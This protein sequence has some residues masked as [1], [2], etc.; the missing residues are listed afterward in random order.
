[1]Q[2]LSRLTLQT[3]LIAALGK[4]LVMYEA[5]AIP[6]WQGQGMHATGENVLASLAL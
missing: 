1:M 6:D 2:P 4:D 5:P 3:L